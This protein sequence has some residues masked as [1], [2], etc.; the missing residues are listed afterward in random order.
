MNPLVKKINAEDMFNLQSRQYSERLLIQDTVA[1]G[2]TKL[3]KVSISN[4]GHFFCTHITGSFSSLASPA[5]AIVD[6]GIDYLA[7]QLI[8]GAGQRKLFNDRIP[9]SLWL[10]P[11][12]R[13]DSSSTT[14]LT[15]PESNNLFYPIE[16]QYL[17][18]ANSDILLDVENES[19]EDNTYEICFHGIRLVSEMVL[20]G[21]NSIG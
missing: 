20:G 15:D 4:L 3:G 11:G 17:F 8:D 18:N 21:R 10:S 2:T 1:A 16:F 19:D 7:G 6:T 12:R 13:R 14:V 5:A 9:F